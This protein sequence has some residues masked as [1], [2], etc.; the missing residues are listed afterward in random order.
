MDDSDVVVDLLDE[1][2]ARAWARLTAIEALAIYLY[3]AWL[4]AL[5]DLERVEREAADR[6]G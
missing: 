5:G 1:R 4:L 6:G 3:A 2:M